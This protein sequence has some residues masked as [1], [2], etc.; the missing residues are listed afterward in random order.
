MSIRKSFEGLGL[1]EAGSSGDF[2]GLASFRVGAPS[3]E[4]G[5]AG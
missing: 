5:V 3:I 2:E 4:T 1:E